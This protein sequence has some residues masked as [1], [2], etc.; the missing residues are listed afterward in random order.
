M[1]I[2]RRAKGQY[3]VKL[4]KQR[5][6]VAT[7]TFSTLKDAEQWEAE[8]KIEL[9]SGKIVNYEKAK[10]VSLGDL[11]TLYLNKVTPTKRGEKS[12]TYRIN[13]I[14]KHHIASIM[15][16]ELKVT[17][18]DLYTEERS[19]TVEN[20]TVRH[21]LKTMIAVINYSIEK[22]IIHLSESP[23][24]GIT[25]P[26]L[27]KHRTRRLVCDEYELLQEASK[28]HPWL[29]NAIVLAV[30]TAMR[31]GEIISITVAD[32]NLKTRQIYLSET[33]NG[34]PRTIPLSTRAV[35]VLKP[36]MTNHPTDKLFDIE[37]QSLT[38][39]FSNACK[40]ACKHIYTQ[41]PNERRECHKN[42]EKCAGILGL[43]FHDLRHE[44][45]SRLFENTTLRT[46][47]IMMITGHKSY[48]S[49]KIYTNL[50]Q[51]DVIAALG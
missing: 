23:T 17:D 2:E 11:L 10:K 42:G 28:F 29:R 9:K 6:V 40:R 38:R 18:F 35:E 44:A 7:E 19:K 32:V 20:Q 15:M 33:K 34:D 30:E 22:K 21:E 49:L 48:A 50:R 26:K 45:T 25:L 8:K 47:Q 43:R 31:R 5:K 24:A 4:Y 41:K 51:S 12:E 14:L 37:P 16:N 13:G 27:P 46:E 1:A 39:A 36:L 3:R